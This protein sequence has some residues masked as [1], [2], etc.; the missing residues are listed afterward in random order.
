MALLYGEYTQEEAEELLKGAKSRYV[1]GFVVGSLLAMLAV[2]AF[3][4]SW[5]W[6]LQLV[7]FVFAAGFLLW[8]WWFAD[9]VRNVRVD[10]KD[11]FS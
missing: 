9:F 1:L 8:A 5:S 6:I 3:F 4:L 7:L 2:V 11:T 10:M